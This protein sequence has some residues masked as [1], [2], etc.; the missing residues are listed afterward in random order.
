MFSCNKILCKFCLLEE[1]E[2]CSCKNYCLINQNLSVNQAKKMKNTCDQ[3]LE[4]PVCGVPLVKRNY[5]G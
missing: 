5:N 1:I 3:C 2:Y 4:C